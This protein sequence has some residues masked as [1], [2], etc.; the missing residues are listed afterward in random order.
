MASPFIPPPGY[1]RI[2]VVSS[3]EELISTPLVDGVNALCWQRT[4]AGDFGEVV[5]QLGVGKGITTIDEERLWALTLSAEGNIAREVLLQD[6][7]LLRSREL[8]PVL[9]CINGYLHEDE[10]APVPT[11]VQSFHVDSATVAADTYL[12]TYHGP[13]SE[14]LR[15][16]EALRKVEIPQTRAELLKLYGGADD[17]DFV[18]YLNDHYYDLHY[19]S[20]PQAQPFDFGLGNLWRIACEYPGSPVPPCVHRA[21]LTM[22]GQPTRLLLIS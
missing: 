14:G 12:C 11:H 2:K 4:L 22:P 7:D 1:N 6:Q 18:E 9:D 16:D 15:N 13:S 17:D 20:V 8:A 19:A 10:G 5:A 3:F 21:P